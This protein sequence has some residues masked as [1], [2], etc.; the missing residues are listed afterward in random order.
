MENPFMVDSPPKKNKTK[1]KQKKQWPGKLST[2]SSPIGKC[3]LLSYF[4]IWHFRN[5]K[6]C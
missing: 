4:I 3:A 2:F 6:F 5:M 1:Q